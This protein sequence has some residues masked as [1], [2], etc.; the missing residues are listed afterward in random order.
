MLVTAGSFST[1][2]RW[3]ISKLHKRAPV[4]V[5]F[6]FEKLLFTGKPSILLCTVI[7]SPYGCF[8]FIPK[9]NFKW[10]KGSFE[11]LSDY[12]FGP[13]KY[14]HSFCPIDGCGIVLTVVERPIVAVNLRSVQ[15]IDLDKIPKKRLDGRSI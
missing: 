3:K 6:A 4:T 10:I 7:D 11:E 14:R 15:D 5:A 2:S 13:K 1:N 8:S 9:E 12:Q